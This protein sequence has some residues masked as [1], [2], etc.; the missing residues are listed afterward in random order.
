MAF[1]SKDDLVRLY[2]EESKP[3]YVVAR[4]LNI[5][6][7]TVYNYLKRYNIPSRPAMTADTRKKISEAN[8]GKYLGKKRGAMSEETKKKLSDSKKGKF[9]KPSRFGGHRK[10]RGDGYIAVY[11][12]KHRRAT[13]D[14]YVMEHILVA[15]AQ[16]GRCLTDDEVVHHKNKDRADNRIENL[17]VMTFKEHAALHVVERHRNGSIN[18]FTVPVT[19]TTTGEEFKSAV[20][21]ARAYSVSATSITRA[22]KAGYRTVKGCHWAYTRKE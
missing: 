13:R 15:E 18:Y 10:H 19:N 2:V 11:C 17:Q 16:L 6:V 4:E 7:G 9:T 8:K 22:C 14:G 21:A 12:P 20:E 3:M 5:A 1:V